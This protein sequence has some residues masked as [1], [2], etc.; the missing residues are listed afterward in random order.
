[1]SVKAKD[2]V[3][4]VNAELRKVTW[5]SKKDTYGSTLVVIIVVLICGVFLGV[6]DFILSRLISLVLG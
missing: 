6:V 3:A 5:P 4:N 2:F 1:M